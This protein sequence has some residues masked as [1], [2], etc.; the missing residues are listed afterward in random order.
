MTWHVLC[1]TARHCLV[2]VVSRCWTE[3]VT[4]AYLR[5]D[6]S[7]DNVWHVY[8]FVMLHTDS[9]LYEI[10]NMLRIKTMT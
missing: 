4:T 10:T 8:L 3:A 1:G 6:V 5:P 2:T 9:Y 7:S